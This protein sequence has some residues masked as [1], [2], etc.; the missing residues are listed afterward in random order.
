MNDETR[1][2]LLIIGAMKSGTT[3]LYA[4]LSQHPQI[5]PC[6]IKEPNFFAGKDRGKSYEWY[7]NL[8]DSE[9]SGGKILMEGSTHYTKIPQFPNAA[10]R[11]A[12][13][14]GNYKF[15]Y[16]IRNPIDR[17]ESHYTHARARGWT[18]E[19]IDQILRPDSHFIQVSS[20]A[21]Q[22]REYYMRFPSSDILILSFEDMKADPAR[23]LTDT[24]K[25]LNIDSTYKF[26]ETTKAH[27]EG[28]D[29]KITRRVEMIK[30][31]F[32]LVNRIKKYIPQDLKKYV[33]GLLSDNIV[34]RFTF[35]K[36]Q[37]ARGLELLIDDLHAL[38]SEFGFD[39]GS[40]GINYDSLH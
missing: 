34:E 26:S 19:S 7:K 20:Y 39:I 11:I 5:L 15:I 1:Q 27:N 36:E 35:S 37:K 8:W 6:S 22:I 30:D 3:S 29:L 21:K 38:E 31:K 25:F 14:K 24:C 18:N 16:I 12:T 40:M 4:Y 32:P 13:F 33:S 9:Q 28:R 10:E 17:I 2:F 23:L